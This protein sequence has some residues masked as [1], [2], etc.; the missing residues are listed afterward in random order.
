MAAGAGVS[1]VAGLGAGGGSHN[2]VVAVAQSGNLVSSVAV[3]AGAGVGGVAGL[4]AGGGSHNGVVAVAQSG[5]NVATIAVTTVADVGGIAILS[6]GGSSDHRQVAVAGGCNDLGIGLAASADVS[7]VAILS[8]GG[9]GHNGLIAVTQSSHE[10]GNIAVA[11]STGVGGEAFLGAGG[12]SH[13]SGVNMNAGGRDGLGVGITASAGVGG[14]AFLGASGLHGGG[15]INMLAGSGD[16]LGVGLATVAG[17]DGLAVLAAGGLGDNSLIAVTQSGHEISNIAFAASAGVSGEAFLGA[18]GSG[19][20]SG[21]SMNA[22]G[23]DGLGVGITASA[24]VGGVAFLGAS[25]LHG[26]GSINMLAG[27]GD[28]LGVGL[29]TVA[30]VDGLA[31]LA[32]GGLGHNG[33]I[34]V[35]QGSGAVSNIA[36]AAGAGVSGKAFLGAGGS[37]H[38][39]VVA[40]TQG[41]DDLSVGLAAS[42]GVNGVTFLGAGGCH[43]G[44]SINMLAG[45][46]DHLGVSITA[47]AGVGSEAFLSASGCSHNSVVAVTQGCDFLGGGLTA[48]SA[49]GG[50][51]A[52]GGASCCNGN[53]FVMMRA[54]GCD[55]FHVGVTAGSTGIGNGTIGGAGGINSNGFIGML[56][57]NCITFVDLIQRHGGTAGTGRPTGVAAVIQIIA[58][59]LQLVGAERNG[60]TAGG[61]GNALTGG[62][63]AVGQI[64]IIGTIAQLTV[65]VG[66]NHCIRNIG[67]DGIIGHGHGSL[68]GA[69]SVGQRIIGYNDH[70]GLAFDQ[71]R[72]LVIS[73]F[74]CILLAVGC[75]TSLTGIDSMGTGAVFNNGTAVIVAACRNCCRLGFATIGAVCN[76]VA[77]L[78]AGRCHKLRNFPSVRNSK[79]A[80]DGVGCGNR[81]TGGV[82]A[83]SNVIA[84]D[85]HHGS[86][87][88]LDVTGIH[89]G[90]VNDAGAAALGRQGAASGNKVNIGISRGFAGV[91]MTPQEND[92]VALAGGVQCIHPGSTTG[93]VAATAVDRHMAHNKN[94]LG[95]IGSLCPGNKVGRGSGCAGA[96]LHIVLIDGVDIVV[97]ALIHFAGTGI[98]IGVGAVCSDIRVMSRIGVEGLDTGVD[99]LN[100]AGDRCQRT[101]IGI[102]D[103]VTVQH[104]QAGLIRQCIQ[105]G[106]QIVGIFMQVTCKE[107]RIG[108]PIAGCRKGG[109]RQK[110]QDHN[111][112]QQGRKHSLYIGCQFHK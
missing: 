52:G 13:N 33:L 39:S 98:C 96:G 57:G 100:G 50:Y 97:L 104:D 19:D 89:V 71:G 6:A 72:N 8:A 79:T 24:G 49:G 43:G 21:I 67:S 65:L 59:D 10:I 107:D 56:T 9:S 42:A 32:A 15:S 84:V 86:V 105:Q 35:A 69:G 111:E 77:I 34:A 80:L 75:A 58:A 23:R 106:L 87:A 31:V 45:G 54:V 88:I 85:N 110:R 7:G 92:V 95:R 82:A 76:L 74:R 2:S 112:H 103:M 63:G 78:G 61:E 12:S 55:H 46:R 48:D 18:G 93:I 25:G 3:A 70:V 102:V 81:T 20:D 99:A 66:P 91:V 51:E 40:V 17:V 26:G 29:A 62:A 41:C 64:N 22:G 36:V 90:K 53:G 109:H 1:G 5:H 60:S 27:S 37:S 38:N 30:G 4:G 68:A 28:H 14:V 44:G 73:G 83:N 11:A 94:N 16:H 108:L 47:V 101:T